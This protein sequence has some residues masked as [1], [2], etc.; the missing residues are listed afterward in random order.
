MANVLDCSLEVS[1][2]EHQSSDYVH[3]QTD[4]LGKKVNPP[5]YR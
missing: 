1:T 4:T 3:F 2:F 5:R